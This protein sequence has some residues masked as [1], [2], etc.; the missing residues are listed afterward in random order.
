[1]MFGFISK[2][3]LADDLAYIYAQHEP[4][5]RNGNK[6]DRLRAW[7]AQSAINWL[8]GQYFS[9]KERVAA[10]RKYFDIIDKKGEHNEGK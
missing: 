5:S 6:E 1:M 9:E 10:I 7:E 8:F 4:A 3:K 2:K